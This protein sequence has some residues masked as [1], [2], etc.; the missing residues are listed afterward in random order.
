MMVSDDLRVI[1]G[2]LKRPKMMLEAQKYRSMM[3]VALLAHYGPGAL[4][5]VQR[6]C[7]IIMIIILEYRW[8]QLFSSLSLDHRPALFKRQQYFF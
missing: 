7:I 1:P 2:T 6:F 8:I 4:T 3:T 5:D